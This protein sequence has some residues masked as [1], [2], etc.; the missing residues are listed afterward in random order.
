LVAQAFT[1]QFFV[2]KKEC[3]K[4]SAL[5]GFTSPEQYLLAGPFRK[6]SQAHGG[7]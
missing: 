2:A 1:S 4:K 3:C 7:M 5:F 6:G